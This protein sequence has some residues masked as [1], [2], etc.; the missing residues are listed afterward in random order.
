VAVTIGGANT[1]S[2]FGTLSAAGGQNASWVATIGY[3]ENAGSLSHGGCGGM[4]VGGS[5][6]IAGQ[7]GRD[8]PQVNGTYYAGGGGGSSTSTGAAGGLGGG[9]TA[10]SGYSVG[11]S[12]GTNGLGGGGGGRMAGGSGRVMVWTEQTTREAFAAP[13]EPVIHAALDGGVMVGAYAID[14]VAPVDTLG[15]LVPFPDEP[16]PTGETWTDDETGDTRPVLAWPEKGWTYID[17]EWSPPND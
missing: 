3:A 5:T 4:N 10:M 2:S 8:G 16:Q 1:A 15:Q 17:G 14:P 6:T 12:N 7:P 9:G 11:G 13:V